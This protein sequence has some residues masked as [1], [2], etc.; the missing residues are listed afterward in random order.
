MK[1]TI[2]L[3]LTMLT[4]LTG[5]LLFFVRGIG[6][7]ILFSICVF[8]LIIA[9]RDSLQRRHSLLRSYPLV[10]RLRW[11]FEEEREKI[12]QYFIEDDLN[13]KPLSREQRSL[14]YQRAKKQLETVPFGTQHNLYQ[15]GY[16]FVK[17]S[18]FPKNHHDVT[19]DKI[20]YGSDKCTQKFETSILSIS[21][22]SFGSL[23]KNA[24]MALN[25]GAKMGGFSHNTGE[26]SISPYHLQGGDIVFQIGR[27]TSA[28]ILKTF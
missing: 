7:V 20:V 4:L 10:A 28:D 19:G 21:A 13:G 2:L 11:V 6:T 3:T 12:Q 18:L 22:M 17:H 15:D 8:L 25:Q 27:I 1:K 5:T 26:G 16:E 24:I 23:S 14:V 9:I